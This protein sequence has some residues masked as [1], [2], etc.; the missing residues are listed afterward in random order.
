MN[1][2]NKIVLTTIVSIIFVV[3]LVSSVSARHSWWH[4]WGPEPQFAPSTGILSISSDPEKASVY[5]NS[6]LYL[7]GTTGGQAMSLS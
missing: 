5:I 4:F 1:R 2:K 3:L 7:G 6:V